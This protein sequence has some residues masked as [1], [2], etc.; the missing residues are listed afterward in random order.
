MSVPVQS[1][2]QSIRPLLQTGGSAVTLR[3]GEAWLADI[4]QG[5]SICGTAVPGYV[6]HELVMGHRNKSVRAQAGT[7]GGQAAGK[8]FCE[9]KGWLEEG[10]LVN[11]VSCLL[12]SKR[13][14]EW[15]WGWAQNAK[16]S[17]DF[18]WLEWMAPAVVRPLFTY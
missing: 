5:S 8:E 18:L 3:A 7:V 4:L 12:E 14:A 10:C 1:Y 11:S 9:W 13:M 6:A 15:G 16:L 17:L 2:L